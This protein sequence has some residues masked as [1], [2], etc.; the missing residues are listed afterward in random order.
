MSGEKK[1]PKA[2]PTKELSES[3]MSELF[4]PIAR[5]GE[6]F[7]RTSKALSPSAQT[8]T[9]VS[10]YC[11][12]FG[13]QS[14]P[15]LTD[16][17]AASMKGVARGDLQECEA[18]LFGQAAA[19]QSIF[20]NL[21][22][23]ATVQRNTDHYEM[24]LRLGM[25]AQSQCRATLET[26]AAIKNPPNVAFVKQANIGQAVQVNNAP[27]AREIESP[28]IK[29]LEAD[30]GNGLDTGKAKAPVRAHTTREAVGVVHRST[31]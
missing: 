23:Q 18:M 15:M 4:Q 14:V 22:L 24:Y 30:C 11:D 29:L 2:E 9:V 12:V 5:M 26:L 10:E 8:A 20:T 19:L 31:K 27:R 28:P 17:L 3:E 1:K 6:M 25:K 21:A 7:D 16:A 13:K